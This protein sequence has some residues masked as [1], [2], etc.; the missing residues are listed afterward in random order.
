MQSG[1]AVRVAGIH[2]GARGEHKSNRY[3]IVS[4]CGNVEGR[5]SIERR[6]AF[7]DLSRIG[8]ALQK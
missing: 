6:I 5:L 1:S 7:C 8:A 4:F 2:L 3:M